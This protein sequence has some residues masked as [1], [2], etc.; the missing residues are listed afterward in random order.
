M[1]FL[2]WSG[3]LMHLSIGLILI[4]R[5]YA[6]YSQNRILLT[7]LLLMFLAQLALEMWILVPNALKSS[8]FTLPSIFTGCI[9]HNPAAYLWAYWVP[10][11]VLEV[12]LCVL[13]VG[14]TVRMC[15]HSGRRSPIL[16]LLLRDSVLYFGGVLTIIVAN[17]V[18]WASARP[19]LFDAFVGTAF[20]VHSILGCRILLNLQNIAPEDDEQA[21]ESDTRQTLS[22]FALTSFTPRTNEFTATDNICLSD[23]YVTSRRNATQ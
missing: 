20:A 21:D 13:A 6:M 12:T 11:T 1:N 10:M 16:T 9:P 22:G 15:R 4:L 18:I 7:V 5:I 17:L 3:M 23:L 19:S 2:C 8:V 14:K